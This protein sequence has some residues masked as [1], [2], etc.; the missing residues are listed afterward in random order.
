MRFV[1]RAARAQ[2][3]VFPTDRSEPSTPTNTWHFA[4]L[5]ANPL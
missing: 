3:A 4:C 2:R 5:L 1:C